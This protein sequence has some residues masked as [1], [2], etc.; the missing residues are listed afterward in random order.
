[1]LIGINVAFIREPNKCFFTEGVC[2]TLAWTTYISESIECLVD[3]VSTGCGTTRVSIIIGQLACGVLM[4]ATC[5][6]YLVIYCAIFR[7]PQA[8]KQSQV[9]TIPDAVMAPVYPGHPKSFPMAIS[10]H[11]QSCTISSL[12]YQDTPALTMAAYPPTAPPL[13]IDGNFANFN[14][15]SPYATVYPQLGNERF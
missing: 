9:A 7:R 14:P 3:G 15:A 6:T 4:A 8:A 13:P 11:H 12:P 5:L 1:M 10:H 2:R